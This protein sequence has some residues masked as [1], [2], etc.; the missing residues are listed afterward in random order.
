MA[1][2]AISLGEGGDTQYEDHLLLKIIDM[3]NEIYS[4]VDEGSDAPLISQVI[5]QLNDVKKTINLFYEN[6]AKK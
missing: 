3:Y 4:E 6:L 5:S 2:F 1:N